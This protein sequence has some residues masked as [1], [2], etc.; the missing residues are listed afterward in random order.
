MLVSFIGV[1]FGTSNST[2]GFSRAGEEGARLLALEA[3]QPTLPSAM[4]FPFDDS[5]A[6]FGRA[7]IDAYVGGESGRLMR[8]LKSVLGSALLQEKTRL[9]RRSLTFVEILGAFF[10]F[11]R[12]SAESHLEEPIRRAVFGR[13]V[14]FV[15]DDDAADAA[16]EAALS[17][18]ARTAGFRDVAFQ[19]EPIAA[20]LDYEQRVTREET[21]LIVD[22]GGGTSDFS[23][24]RVS[25]ERAG[26]SDRRQ[27]VLANAGVH[28][29]GADFDRWLSLAAVMPHFGYGT[30]TLDGKRELP[31]RYYHDLATWQFINRLYSNKVTNEL[32]HIRYGAERRDLV[33][34]FLWLVEEKRGHALALAVER[35]KIDLTRKPEAGIDMR[36]FHQPTRIAIERHVF[37]AAI[38]QGVQKIVATLRN[39]LSQ[40]GLAPAA[41]GHVFVTGGSSS[42]PLLRMQITAMFPAAEFVTGDLFGSVGVGLALD[43]RRKFA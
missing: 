7:A 31:S 39:V 27:D 17:E 36:P 42:V 25:P 34:R 21:V 20:A 37:D 2:I 11:L 6:R 12:G 15:D 3:G 28:V 35:A 19:Y 24:V 43:A 1:D 26:Q 38:D 22:I 14:R 33:D 9:G 18:I 8:A 32:K 41:I 13:P 16:A 5:G 29:G 23:I 4:F 30:R 10:D 40:A